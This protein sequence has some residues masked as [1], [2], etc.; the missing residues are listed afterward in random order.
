MTKSRSITIC[1]LLSMFII[2]F[3]YDMSMACIFIGFKLNINL[4]WLT[5]CFRG[6]SPK[7]RFP[8]CIS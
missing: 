1:D 5:K 3:S 6:L 7:T 8:R 4:P 2:P